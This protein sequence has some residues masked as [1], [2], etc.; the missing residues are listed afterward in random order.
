MIPIAVRRLRQINAW[1]L[2]GQA[3]VAGDCSVSDGR[4]DGGVDVRTYRPA[5]AP[6]GDVM[7][8]FHGGGFISGSIDTHDSLCSH[9]AMALGIRLVS[10]GYRLAPEHPA[11]AQLEDALAACA[12]FGSGY[13][14][15]LGG[16][17]AGGYLAMRCALALNATE[18]GAVAAA[19]LLNPL[20]DM[21]GRA[22]TLSG[23]GRLATRYM[24]RQVGN[25]VYPSLLADDLAIAPPTVLVWGGPLDP[26]APGARRLADALAKAG[27]SV[28][29]HVHPA[30]PHGGLNLTGSSGAAR[31]IV[32][33]ASAD[34]RELLAA[35][36]C[37]DSESSVSPPVHPHPPTA[38]P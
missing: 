4:R 17:S 35:D 31:R 14:L 32:V 38:E 15:L 30:L 1:S 22:E 16:D 28:R 8:Y 27:V 9:V 7:V 6:A 2:R 25:D 36:T 21:A 13:R 29:R 19:L 11:P 23:P 24:R 33:A 18:P 26:V 3:R 12:R 20:I 37:A 10:V 5:N 34:V